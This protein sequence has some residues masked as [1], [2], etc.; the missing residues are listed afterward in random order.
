LTEFGSGL[1][2]CP[3]HDPFV[4][5]LH[6]GDISIITVVDLC[7]NT[8]DGRVYK[9]YDSHQQTGLV[10]I[11]IDRRL[12]RIRSSKNGHFLVIDRGGADLPLRKCR[13][14]LHWES[15]ERIDLG[16]LEISSAEGHQRHRFV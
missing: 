7:G 10:K 9:A 11:E 3:S 6:A 8:P 4:R 14:D 1:T 13:F 12:A 15:D 5:H 16:A 2:V